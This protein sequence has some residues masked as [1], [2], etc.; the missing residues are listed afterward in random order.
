MKICSQAETEREMAAANKL[1]VDFVA[2]GEAAYPA[3]CK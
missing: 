3:R 1:G 2:L